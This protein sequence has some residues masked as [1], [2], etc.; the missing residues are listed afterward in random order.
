MFFKDKKC[1]G[2]IGGAILVLIGAI[3]WG[4]VGVGSFIGSNLNV[5]NLLFGSWSWLENVIY[6]VVGT[7]GI[8]LIVGCKCRKCCG[9]KCEDDKCCDHDHA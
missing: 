4:L 2:A 1:P 6:I 9:D 7:A 8:L 3:N 5:V